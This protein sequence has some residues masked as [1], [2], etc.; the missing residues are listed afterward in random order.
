MREL[1]WLLRVA[2]P[3]AALAAV[4]AL[5]SGSLRATA[6]AAGC[7]PERPLVPA[8]Q[9]SPAGAF[10]ISPLLDGSGTLA[11][12]RLELGTAR[13]IASRLALPA[14]SFAAGPFGHAI[15]VGADDGRR[16]TLRAVEATTGCAWPL[17][18]ETDV[19]RRATIDSAAGNVYEFRVDRATRADLGVWRR[20][21]GGG[22]AARVLAPLPADDRYGPTFSTELSWS[23]EGDV[24]V[25]Q[26]CG[27][28][29]CRTRLLD[30]ATA[31]VRTLESAD[32]GE[33]IG[34]AAGRLIT[35]GACRGLPCNIAS[36][37]AVTGER[38][39]LAPAARAARLV[40][41]SHGPRLLAE[42]GTDDERALVVVDPASAASAPLPADIHDWHL[43]PSAPR[44]DGALGVP[45][46]W[47]L[48]TRDGQAITPGDTA[49]LLRVD[50]GS[51][52]GLTE[53]TR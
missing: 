26:S 29:S 39:T 5:G 46:G 7:G 33:V 34:L 8:T 49:Q 4:V 15:L 41:T 27:I 50:D 43:V 6:V 42:V 47:A 48:L 12:Q 3:F 40:T 25:V 21:L 23:A 20:P 22:D 52:V 10:V 18:T 13:L 38:T 9:A 37:D 14:E 36:V 30:I 28:S 16:S 44:A 31:A 11:G 35:F 32:Q 19:I 51:T 24:L 17:A 2:P 1:R 45:P 53:V